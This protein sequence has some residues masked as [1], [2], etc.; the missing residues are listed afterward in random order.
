VP[1]RAAR[2]VPKASALDR[3]RSFAEDN[4]GWIAL[5]LSGILALVGVVAIRR[6]RR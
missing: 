3:A 2:A 6:F 5:V 1:L 4:P